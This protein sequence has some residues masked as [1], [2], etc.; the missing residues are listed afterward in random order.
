[1]TYNGKTAT[2]SVGDRVSSVALVSL[3][4]TL[5]NIDLPSAPDVL[6]VVSTFPPDCSPSSHPTTRA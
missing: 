6:L 2:A 1:M 4:A 3:P 5:T